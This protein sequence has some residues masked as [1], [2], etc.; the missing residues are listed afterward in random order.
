[1]DENTKFDSVTLIS[2]DVVCSR[3]QHI[4]S[5]STFDKFFAK[6]YRSTADMERA[7]DLFMRSKPKPII[8]TADT[9]QKGAV[10]INEVP[11]NELLEIIQF[12]GLQKIEPVVF[13]GIHAF[14]HVKRKTLY[15]PML[16]VE[17]NIVGYKKLARLADAKMTE[18]TVPEQNSFGA[19]IFPP[20]IKRGFRDQRTAILVVNML[21]ALA[22]RMEKNNGGCLKDSAFIR[23]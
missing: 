23:N 20:I 1:M 15:F 8:L 5:F 17:S 11:T 7:R 6:S 3:C 18:T 14:C 12:L 21:D 9:I 22:L 19:V 2:G 10:P 13:Q 4:F 16:D